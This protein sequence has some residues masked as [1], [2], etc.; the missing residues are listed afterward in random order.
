MADDEQRPERRD[1]DAA[2][3][4]D[5]FLEA[6]LGDGRPSP[7]AV[8]GTD[9]AEMARMAAELAASGRPGAESAP[10]PAFVEQLRRRM[11]EAD[12][13]ID[14]IRQPPPVREQP[15]AEGS[16]RWRMSRR[17]PLQA[18]LGAAAGM[19]AGIVGVSLAA[20]GQRQ[21]TIGGSQQLVAGEGFWTDVAR[22][23][24]CHPARAPVHHRGLRRLRRQR[25]GTIRALSSV[26]T[27]MGCTL[28]FRPDWHD[29]RLSVPRREL[30]PR[31]RL[32][33]GRQAARLEGPI[34]ATRRP[35]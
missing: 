32:A 29:L 8:G 12:A 28:H 4:F 14:A 2:E 1:E 10:D 31:R 9:E 25:R 3:R 16:A 33:N 11:Q 13:G 15:K 34:L 17:Q 22:L 6:L 23:D 27:H 20:R 35:T 26:C 21:P 7:D 19:A 18:G 30:R 24:E 5:G